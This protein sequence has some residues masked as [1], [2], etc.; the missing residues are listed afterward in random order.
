MGASF[1]FKEVSVAQF[2]V[3]VLGNGDQ[4]A[5]LDRITSLMELDDAPERNSD[6]STA[7][8]TLCKYRVGPAAL[9]DANGNLLCHVCGPPVSADMARIWSIR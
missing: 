6:L 8:C 4:N 3:Q 2:L 5:A 9:W 7:P 1:L